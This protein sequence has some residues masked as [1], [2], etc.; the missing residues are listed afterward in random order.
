MNQENHS[1]D[2]VGKQINQTGDGNIGEVSG[3]TVNIN[4]QAATKAV[5]KKMGGT[6]FQSQIFL[7]RD[8]DIQR[9]HNRLWNE[10]NLLL[11]MNGEGGIG[12]TTLGSKYYLQYEQEYNH[13]IW[14][15]A[16]SGIRSALFR[17]TL[18]LDL[19]WDANVSEEERIE[20]LLLKLSNLNK[21]CLMILDNTNEENDLLQWTDA[22]S[23][24]SNFH[25]LFTTRV[26]ELEEILVYKVSALSE[27]DAIQLFEKYY[28]NLKTSE[29]D[30]LKSL[31]KAIGYNTVGISI[32]SLWLLLNVRLIKPTTSSVQWCRQLY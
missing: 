7:G 26:Q 19:K 24:L 18:D 11:L 10:G 27:T 9:I 25:I 17:L 4:F 5:P 13:L 29:H 32:R 22:L 30:L 6:P 12:K 15:Y 2:N 16:D 28:P 21:Q 8:E 14:L 1:G 23:R 3:G 20:Q 31:L